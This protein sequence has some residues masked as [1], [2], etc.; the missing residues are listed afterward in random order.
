MTILGFN[1]I[2]TGLFRTLQGFL[3]E[4]EIQ[5]RYNAPKLTKKNI[6]DA[7]MEI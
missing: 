1:P 5:R 2:R 4:D 3:C 7:I 6:F